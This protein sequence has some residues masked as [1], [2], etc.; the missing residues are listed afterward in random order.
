MLLSVGVGSYYS[1]SYVYDS[2]KRVQAV[3]RMIDGRN[4][5]TSFQYNTANRFTQIIY[6]SGR[7]INIGHDTK[8]RVTSVGSFLSSVT[9]NSIGQMVGTTLGNG[10]TESFGYHADRLHLTSQKAGTVAPH[11]NR[12]NLTYTFDAAA[13]QMGAGTTA[14]NAGQLMAVSGTISG[15]GSATESASNTYDN[16]GR[17]ATSSQTSNGQTAQRRFVYDRWGN[18]TAVWDAVSG[19]NQIQNAVLQQSG[20]VPTNQLISVTN[21]GATS[22]YSYDA[23]GN[24]INDG[25]HSYTYDAENRLVSV[26]SGATAQYGYDHQNQRV[27]KTTGGAT[28]QY[29]WQDS[30]VIAE[31]NG[32]TGALL[33]E[34]IYSGSRLVAKVESGVTTYFLSDPL[35]ARLTLDGGGNVVGKQGR[36]PFGE[37]FAETGIQEKHHFT[38]YERDAETG[39]DYAVNRVYSPNIARFMQHDPY[40]G[41]GCDS[42]NPQKAQ[43]L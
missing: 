39:L 12:M 20:G 34:Y 28:V 31:Y 26:D 40:K 24:V 6:P 33:A 2:D 4:H 30:H 22:N 42:N 35:G 7:V 9:Y 14:G 38:T 29:V 13:G 21:G 3:T 18:R 23:S 16:V 1:E 41:G 27:K 32:G 17:L 43:S 5:T 25:G 19:G 11:T 10:V 8:D 36:L 37:D 15:G